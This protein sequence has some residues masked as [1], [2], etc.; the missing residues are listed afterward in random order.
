M[1]VPRATYR[2]Q[3]NKQFTFAQAAEILQYLVQLG[4][5]DCY[6]S[7]IFRAAPEST[8]GYD[9]CGFEVNPVL[10]GAA[11]FERFAAALHSRGMGL[12]LDIV[13]NH[14]GN[15]LSNCWWMDVLEFGP[16]SKYASFFDIDWGPPD[17]ASPG[18]VLVPI[19]GDHYSHVLERGELRVTQ[20]NS[21]FYIAYYEN[22][23]PISPEGKAYLRKERASFSDVDTFLPNLNGT[24]GKAA[25]FDKLHHLL[26][27]QHYRL[28]YWK[29]GPEE[30][31]YRRF[32]DVTSLVSMRVE[33]PEVFKATHKSIFEWLEDGAINGLRIDHPDGLWNPREYCERLQERF[34]ELHPGEKLYIVVEKILSGDEKLPGDWP[35]EGTTGYDFLNK[36]NG[37][38]VE[39]GNENAFT[40]IYEE[41]TGEH[42]DFKESIYHCKKQILE[43]SLIAEAM[44]LANGLSHLA[45]Q[46]RYTRD[47]TFAQLHHALIEVIACFPVYRTYADEE[48]TELPLEEQKDIHEAIKR[49]KANNPKTDSKAFEFLQTLLLLDSLPDWTEE[50]KKSA[51]EWVMKFQ[52]L[53]GPATAKGL[54]DTAF[55]R[56]NRLVSLNE[57]GGEPARFGVT[58]DDFH[59]YNLYQARH[60][61]HSLLAT[62]T[63]DTKR[64]EDIRAHLNVLSEIPEEWSAVV[65][66][67]AVAN[68][69]FKDLVDGIEAPSA[70]D[71][72]L[73][74]QTLVGAWIPD[75]GGAQHL[76]S[77]RE[78]VTA[79]MLKAVKEA[80]QHTSWTDPNEP[81]ENAI[82][83]FVGR[84][85]DLCNVEFL[86]EFLPFQQKIAFF[87]TFNSL[88]QVLIKATAPGVPDFYQGT[89]LWDLNLVDPDN[90]QPV[91][92]S[93]RKKL[94]NEMGQFYK[95]NSGSCLKELVD[96]F[97][98]PKIKLFT[99]W[100]TLNLR[101]EKQALFERGEY[102]PL[103]VSRSKARHLCVFARK[104]GSE[105]AIT[106]AP[107]FVCSLTGS[108]AHQ[109]LGDVWEETVIDARAA[110]A[111]RMKNILT[112][113]E[114]RVQNGLIRVADIFCDFPL[115][116]LSNV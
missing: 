78:R 107:R 8:H 10:G 66:R 6:A 75:S 29:I 61:P 71:E 51:R 18:K 41:F 112:G 38:F 62:S 80:K 106:V 111:N 3:F 60:W 73:L 57:V 53:T 56:L 19:L 103:T 98:N 40:S 113:E 4:I 108:Q 89:E 104:M 37:I 9:V 15:H 35:V 101:K 68:R 115:A 67:W 45:K 39:S 54:E 93:Q 82:K 14:M 16:K 88:S 58:L 95:N 28:A 77:L 27:L 72:Y 26:E 76:H 79:Y 100:R 13:P 64:G 30:L 59:Q 110:E 63:H 91:D 7:P 50:T 24:P 97:A 96:N 81:Y 86:S 87:G 32:F 34:G 102:L 99:L 5:S 47:F 65:R 52:Q 33:L 25:T 1:R 17:S 49:A 42:L 94:L 105:F 31:N 85:L 109:P 92:Y 44:R 23:F 84:V 90:R 74:Y 48:M 46:S 114:V 12:L 36:L 83:N 43:Q 11:E 55:Y 69:K 70:N 21:E 116:L 20:E 2:L 22:R